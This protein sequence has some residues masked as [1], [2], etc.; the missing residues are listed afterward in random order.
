[1]RSGITSDEA[2][3]FLEEL[4]DDE[5]LRSR[6]QENPREV[7]LERGIDLLPGTEP[8]TV[9]LPS[10]E[11]IRAYARS[12]RERA[13]FAPDNPGSHGFAVLMVSHGVPPC[14]PPPED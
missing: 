10:P 14:T 11:E 8:R 7:L 1:V 3:A 6:L 2:I 12:L 9:Q 5:G 4:A 13:P